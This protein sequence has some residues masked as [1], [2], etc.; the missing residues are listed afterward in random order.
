M[1]A[2]N[3]RRKRAQWHQKYSRQPFP[4]ATRVSSCRRK[5]WLGISEKNIPHAS[6]QLHQSSVSKSNTDDEIRSSQTPGT[7]VDQAQDEGGQGESGEAQGRRIGES[8]IL[9]LLVET[10]LE[11]TTEG[12]QALF[13]TGSVDMS[14]R[15][16]AEASGS[17]G[18]LMLLVGHLA[19]DAAVAIGFFVVAVGAVAGEFGVGGGH[20]DGEEIFKRP[21]GVEVKVW[22]VGGLNCLVSRMKRGQGLYSNI[23]IIRR[24]EFC[25]KMES[26]GSGQDMRRI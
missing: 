10:R 25:S 12:R 22:L 14:K 18:G 19:V 15:P 16:I 3:R 8:A 20:G 5:L 11:L 21:T 1:K 13:A 7:H 24:G 17:F 26:V 4:C 6:K 2:R 23:R 9:D